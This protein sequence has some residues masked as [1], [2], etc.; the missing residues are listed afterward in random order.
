MMGLNHYDRSSINSSASLE[1]RYHF[2]LSCIHILLFVTVSF[3]FHFVTNLCIGIPQ[4]RT[5]YGL[6]ET[7]NLEGGG[8][9][10]GV[11]SREGGQ[12]KP[13][14]NQRLGLVFGLCLLS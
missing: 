4:F 9:I 14:G 7:G 8:N 13:G 10:A 3:L 2:Q 5:Y 6:R 11:G 12:N 1:L